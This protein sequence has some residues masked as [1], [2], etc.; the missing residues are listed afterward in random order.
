MKTE[1]MLHGAGNGTVVLD[2]QD[3]TKAVRSLVVEGGVNQ[4]PSLVLDLTLWELTKVDGEFDVLVSERAAD[5]LIH[6]GWT[7]PSDAPPLPPGQAAPVLAGPP[8]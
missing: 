3:V 7:P 5:L 4:V 1:I 8:G 6:L 2:G